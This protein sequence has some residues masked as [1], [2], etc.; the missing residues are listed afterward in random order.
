MKR[1]AISFLTCLLT[2]TATSGCVGAL[3]SGYYARTERMINEDNIT[4]YHISPLK[5]NEEEN[6]FESLKHLEFIKPMKEIK[7]KRKYL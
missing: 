3:S 5:E 1:G 6:F 4:Y 7:T 2:I